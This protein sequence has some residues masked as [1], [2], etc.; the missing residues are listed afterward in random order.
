MYG[1]GRVFMKSATPTWDLHLQLQLD[2][3][4]IIVFWQVGTRPCFLWL[5]KTPDEWI[6]VESPHLPVPTSH[7]APDVTNLGICAH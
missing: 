3:G 4:A 2:S 1:L 5:I 6:I 7:P